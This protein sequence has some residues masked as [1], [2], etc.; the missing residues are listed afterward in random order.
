MEERKLEEI[1]Q[2]V[3]ENKDFFNDMFRDNL[4]ASEINYEINY[5]VKY[6]LEKNISRELILDAQIDDTTS[7]IEDIGRNLEISYYD[8]FSCN[9]K[10]LNR[11]L[12]F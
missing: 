8:F 5:I 3:E 2:F 1:K 12:Y 7:S 4:F 6:L 9:K 10:Y 11:A